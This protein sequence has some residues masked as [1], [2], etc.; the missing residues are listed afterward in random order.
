MATNEI[1]QLLQV[2]RDAVR[3]S[4]RPA[5]ELERA[6]GIAHGGLERLLEGKTELRVR[7]LLAFAR[8][9]RVPVAD[10]LELGFP[11]SARTAE[12][13]LAD[14]LRLDEPFTPQKR[15]SAGTPLPSTVEELSSLIRDAVQQELSA[16]KAPQS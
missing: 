5:R 16:L 10:F 7:H 14:W 13:R 1:R 6:L 12:F 15:Q 9:L 3:A 11:E 4:R 8:V 2:L